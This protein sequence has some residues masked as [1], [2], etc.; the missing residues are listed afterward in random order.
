MCAPVCTHIQILIV[1]NR[2]F[3][4]VKPRKMNHLQRKSSLDYFKVNMEKRNWPIIHLGFLTF[5][6]AIEEMLL[7]KVNIY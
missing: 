3:L 7:Y 5:L 1:M 4:E 2:V 6:R